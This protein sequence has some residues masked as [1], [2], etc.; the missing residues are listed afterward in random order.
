MSL[1]QAMGRPVKSVAE[2]GLCFG[3]TGVGLVVVALAIQW[4]LHLIP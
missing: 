4:L 2:H 1:N 3:L